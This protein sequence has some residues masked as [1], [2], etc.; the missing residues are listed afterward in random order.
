MNFKEF[1]DLNE[2]AT[3]YNPEIYKEFIGK[4][5]DLAK[6]LPKE[7]TDLKIFDK[8]A[9]LFAK[10]LYW[11]ITVPTMNA[12]L[13]TRTVST[14]VQFFENG[15][16]VSMSTMFSGKT[17]DNYA[18]SPID[19]TG[20]FDLKFNK[21]GVCTG[22]IPEATRGEVL[23]GI[24]GKKTDAKGLTIAKIKSTMSSHSKMY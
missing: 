18:L 20:T 16:T 21:K 5:F 14:V 3:N 15:A 11:K 2:A 24:T 19:V 8:V 17:D 23:G 7:L 13:Q 22:I 6:P 12:K 4:K 10:V 1:L 9:P